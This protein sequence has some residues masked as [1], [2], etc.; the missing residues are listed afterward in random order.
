MQFSYIG[1][2]C[3]F[4]KT[5]RE[6]CANPDYIWSYKIYQFLSYV[7][8]KMLFQYPLSTSFEIGINSALFNP[9]NLG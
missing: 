5:H 4:E 8:A 3:G 2:L 9:V 7:L 1:N 6:V